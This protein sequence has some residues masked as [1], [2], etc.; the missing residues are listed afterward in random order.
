MIQGIEPPI[1]Q[2]RLRQLPIVTC[3]VTGF[4]VALLF[5]AVIEWLAVFPAPSESVPHS[6]NSRPLPTATHHQDPRE[7]IPTLTD[8]FRNVLKTPWFGALEAESAP[9]PEKIEISKR[10]LKLV[11]VST[12]SQHSESFALIRSGSGKVKTF[13]LEEEVEPGVQLMELTANSAI[14][15]AGEQWEKLYFGSPPESP[16]AAASI[17]D[18]GAVSVQSTP[19]TPSSARHP[20]EISHQSQKRTG[21]PNLSF[22]EIRSRLDKLLTKADS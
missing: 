18:V 7:A 13:R 9:P 6:N 14:L 10:N 20:A 1:A 17:A 2:I 12:S 21:N 3:L 11:G 15:K 5:G 19:S 22:G 4:A 16:S 8:E